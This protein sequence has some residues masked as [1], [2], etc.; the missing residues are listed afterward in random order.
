MVLEMKRVSHQCFYYCWL[1][2]IIAIDLI[3]VTAFPE[4]H[5]TTEQ[6]RRP[7]VRELDASLLLFS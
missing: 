4:S 1:Y 2:Y 6:Q 7:F 3:R 5:Y